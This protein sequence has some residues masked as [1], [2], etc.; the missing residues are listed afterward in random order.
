[1]NL[2]EF[3]KYGAIGLSG[4]LSVLIFYLIYKQSSL[5]TQFNINKN[6]NKSFTKMLYCFSGMCLF[7]AMAGY[8]SEIAHDY[9]TKK[10]LGA[11]LAKAND[12][13]EKLTDRVVVAEKD[14]AVYKAMIDL[15]R[16]ESKRTFKMVQATVSLPNPSPNPPKYT[17]KKIDC[18][19]PEPKEQQIFIDADFIF[20]NNTK[21]ILDGK[22]PMNLQEYQKYADDIRKE[23]DVWQEKVKVWLK[24][25][26]DQ[27][28]FY[29]FANR[30]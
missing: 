6:V 21:R 23:W 5:Q 12:K 4:L 28:Q 20:K 27:K 14:A 30:N 19:I 9:L 25:H 2:H 1:M 7:L 22:N 11:E 26:P 17:I 8:G 16:D 18:P 24:D 3:I 10:D 13:I 29:W 15:I